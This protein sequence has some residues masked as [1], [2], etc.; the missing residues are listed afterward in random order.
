MKTIWK[1]PFPFEEPRIIK[2]PA[3]T[4]FLFSGTDATGAASHWGIVETDAPV[5]ERRVHIVGT[6][7]P[8]PEGELQYI[9]SLIE[10]GLIWHQFIES[11]QSK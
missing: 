5:V 10:N 9:A 7:K 1:F 6:G 11:E 3:G 8:M 2:C 4:E